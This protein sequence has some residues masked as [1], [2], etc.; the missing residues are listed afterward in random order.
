MP[1][2]NGFALGGIGISNLAKQFVSILVQI[3]LRWGTRHPADFSELD[4]EC[5]KTG[6]ISWRFSWG[7]AKNE[8]LEIPQAL[9]TRKATQFAQ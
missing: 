7:R 1:H 8:E 6:C 4:E 2:E 5:A 9:R 3:L